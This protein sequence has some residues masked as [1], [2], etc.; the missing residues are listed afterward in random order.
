MS[1][2]HPILTIRTWFTYMETLAA[3]HV[4]IGHA[5]GGPVRYTRMWLDQLLGEVNSKLDG[6]AC[7]LVAEPYD[8]AFIDNKSNNILAERLV[9]FS[10]IKK[11]VPGNLEA[12]VDAEATCEE[13][14]LDI[15]GRMRKDRLTPGSNVFGDLKLEQ[16]EGTLLP[17]VANGG[18]VG[19]RIQVPVQN[20][21]RRAVYRANRWTN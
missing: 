6:Q 11:V 20:V 4:A 5:A 2:N 1:Q 14:A 18:W 3:E 15:L 13:V 10:V 8:T 21:E 17:M 7:C 9:A 12:T 19:Y 16:A